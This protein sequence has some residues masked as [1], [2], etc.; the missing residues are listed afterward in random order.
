M[1]EQSA[2]SSQSAQSAQSGPST[3]SDRSSQDAGPTVHEFT[4]AGPIDANIQNL[5]GSVTLRAEQGTAVRV[6]LR[7][8]GAAGRELVERMRIRFDGDRLT[9]DAPAEEAQRF[10]GSLSDLFSGSS[11]GGSWS[12]RLAE[13]VRS[14]LRGAEG[15]VGEIDLV[16]VVPAG[17]RVVLHDGAGDVTVRGALARLEARTGTGSLSLERGA[18]EVSRLTTGT[19]DIAVGPAPGAITATTG[20]GD[21]L[22]GPAATTV[23]ATTGTGRIDLARTGDAVSAT[24][25]AGDILIRRADSGTVRARSG[26][27]DV[28]IRVA[29]GTAAHLDLATGFG[30]RDVRLTPA[31]GAG[32]AERTLEIEARSG[33]GDLHVLRAESEPS[34]R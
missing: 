4:A 19:G 26:L 28:T 23:A 32:G 3:P 34:A 33:K 6:E 9:V 21:I 2:P 7:P 29:P 5:R 1:S 11:R 13:G 18:E 12:D 20:T 24:T 22:L 10:G 8:H 25:G 14:A 16:V 27:G 17:S 31:D 30:D 15:L